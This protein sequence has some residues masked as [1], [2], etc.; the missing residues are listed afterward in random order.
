MSF[1]AETRNRGGLAI[2]L[3]FLALFAFTS[4][5]QAAACN[6]LDECMNAGNMQL[7]VSKD[8]SNRSNW[9]Q[10]AARSDFVNAADWNN[11]A[12]LYFIAGQASYAQWAKAVADNY[13]SSAAANSKAA[14][15]AAAQ[16]RY[17][18]G[19][20]DISFR[21]YM[22]IADSPEYDGGTST[23]KGGAGTI[24]KWGWKNKK[25][26]NSLCKGFWKG[27]ACSEVVT[28]TAEGVTR[29]VLDM[30]GTNKK[31]LKT[32]SHYVVNPSTGNVEKIWL[33]C[34]KWT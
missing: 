6:D 24:I 7:A 16:A 20:A 23:A 15:D 17:W 3:A 4:R 21:R 22:F 31:C 34:T 13:S 18:A 10:G 30:L 14:N 12:S 33:E 28:R 2:I 29:W 11:R 1:N 19:Q 9:F 8:L 26:A 5:A 27:T 25:K 32:K